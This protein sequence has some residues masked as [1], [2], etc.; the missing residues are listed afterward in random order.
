MCAC[1]FETDM[2][3]DGRA[4]NAGRPWRFLNEAA[5]FVQAGVSEALVRG[6][7][8][9]RV[10]VGREGVATGRSQP[11]NGARKASRNSVTHTQL[12]ARQTPIFCLHGSRR[13]ICLRVREVSFY[14]LVVFRTP[15]PPVPT[16][17]SRKEV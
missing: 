9:R 11:N 14:H 1:D 13:G 6:S 10:G 8:G 2:E 7:L 5:G 16:H 3:I 17:G 12:M 15:P 4:V